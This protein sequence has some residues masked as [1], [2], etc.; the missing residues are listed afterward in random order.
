MTNVD[1]TGSP[2]G[3]RTCPRI[4]PNSAL[5]SKVAE[6]RNSRD[7][8]EYTTRKEHIEILKALEES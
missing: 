5:I 7:I 4:H 6:R 1:G 8:P 2:D 3:S